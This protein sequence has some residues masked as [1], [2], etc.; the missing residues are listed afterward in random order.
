[1]IGKMENGGGIIEAP[2]RVKHD[3]IYYYTHHDRVI[4]GKKKYREANKEKIRATYVKYCLDHPGKQ[5]TYSARYVLKVKIQTLARYAN[6]EIKCADCGFSD[7]RALSIDHINGG[8]TRHRKEIGGGGTTHFYYWLKTHN[9]PTGYQ[10][11]CMNCQFIKKLVN[12]E[13]HPK[14]A[15]DKAGKLTIGELARL[16][17]AVSGNP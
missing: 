10:V 12:G 2:A 17:E 14:L 8:G 4:Q 6:G 13:N 3:R 9:Y 5:A 7:V 1:M 11:L 15:A 16:Q